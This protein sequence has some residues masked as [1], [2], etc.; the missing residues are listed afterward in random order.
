MVT[1]NVRGSMRYF[2]TCTRV[3]GILKRY[4][5]IALT[6]V[7]TDSDPMLQGF[8]CMHVLTRPFDPESGGVAV[9]VKQHLAPSTAVVRYHAELGMVWLKVAHDRARLSPPCIAFVPYT[10]R[11]SDPRIT[12]PLRM[13]HTCECG[14]GCGSVLLVGD[15]AVE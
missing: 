5:V 14:C 11:M 15:S 4:D 6:H 10:C 1:W 12:Q 8:S 13:W 2:D 9:F 3:M 7:G